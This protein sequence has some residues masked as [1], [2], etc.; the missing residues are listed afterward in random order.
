MD[1][2]WDRVFFQQFP[3][4]PAESC[5]NLQVDAAQGCPAIAPTRD[6]LP[7]QFSAP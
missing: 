3:S 1:F 5:L 2:A 4:C 7:L 6:A